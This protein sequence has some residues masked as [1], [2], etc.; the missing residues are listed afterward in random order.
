M[1]HFCVQSLILCHASNWVNT[2]K[3]QQN[4][5]KT[6]TGGTIPIRDKI[7]ALCQNS[8]TALGIALDRIISIEEFTLSWRQT[9]YSTTSF[10][11]C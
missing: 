7:E 2:S 9:H 8:D 6:A 11:Q 4:R 5:N 10:Y 1:H 3:T